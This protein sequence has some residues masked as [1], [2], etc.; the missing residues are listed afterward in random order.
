MLALQ[1]DHPPTSLEVVGR[2]LAAE[3]RLEGHVNVL[4]VPLERLHNAR[5]RRAV[6][7]I[8]QGA[9]VLEPEVATLMQALATPRYYLRLDTIGFGVPLWAGTRPYQIL[10]FQWTC[11]VHG[12]DGQLTHHG[13]L[14]DEQGDPR[15]A[16]AQSLLQVLGNRG[17]IF[18]YNAGFE[19][20][21]LR[22]LAQHLD[23]LAPALEA[24]VERI[25]DLFQLARA[26][27][28][29]PVMAGSWSFKSISRAVAPEVPVEFHHAQAAT[30]RT[31]FALSFKRGLDAP[32]RQQLRVELQAHGLRETEVLRRMAAL[33]DGASA[34]PG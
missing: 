34:I 28:Y 29:H 31:A 2:E 13:F 19:R 1:P 4:S 12:V 25:V 8:Q 7:A 32:T 15:R 16:F 6:R 9:P 24:V 26:H 21:R 3:L 5:H 33:F 10:P 18:A 11:D 27:Y 17:A 30:A 23:D 20:N 22:E 14:A